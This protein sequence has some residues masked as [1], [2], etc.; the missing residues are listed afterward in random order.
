LTIDLARQDKISTSFRKILIHKRPYFLE[1]YSIRVILGA[2]TAEFMAVA[3]RQKPLIWLK[4]RFSAAVRACFFRI[5]VELI[6]ARMWHVYVQTEKSLDI[7]L[8][9]L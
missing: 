3:E 7:M 4:S 5:R 1:Y 9:L 6:E 8:G 2:N